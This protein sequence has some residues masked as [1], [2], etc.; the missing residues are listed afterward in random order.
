MQLNAMNTRLAA[1]G[2]GSLTNYPALKT[3]WGRLLSLY[4]AH[5]FHC[6]H[7]ALM[8]ATYMQVL[9]IIV[10]DY[11]TRSNLLC[12]VNARATKEFFKDPTY[13]AFYRERF[14]VPPFLKGTMIGTLNG[15][16]PDEEKNMYGRVNDYGTYRFEKELDACPWD[17]VGS[18]YCR[19]TTAFFQALSEGL[20]GPGEP[21]C[22]YN[23]V[24]AKGCGDLH[25]RVIGE[26]REKYPMPP[27]TNPCDTF[28]PIATED[29]IKFTPRE[30]CFKYSQQ[31]WEECEGKYRNGFCAEW[32]A[33]ENFLE[34]AALALGSD[35]VIYV[36]MATQQENME[37]CE[38]IIK[39]LFQGAGKMMFG[40]FA[41]IRGVREWLK[42]PNDVNDCRLL[43]AYIEVILGSIRTPFTEKAFNEEEVV[44]DIDRASLS[45]GLPLL[46]LA[47]V[48]LWYGMSKT[49]IGTEWSVWEETEDVPEETLRIK[50]GRKIDKYCF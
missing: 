17:I 16:K 42:V 47:Y 14:D 18:E 9:R 40:D 22:E 26:H 8:A 38:H 39:C 29:E 23:M 24:E 21:M 2:A 11:N 3:R 31:Y 48:N 28:G 32:T 20:A 49:L 10:P 37:Q 50:I 44:L 15:D 41:G 1:E 25:C 5:E 36:L 7:Y 12:E 6:R 45:K 46:T 34:S 13:Q 4:E 30:K 27:R 19:C 43:A 35:N 33:D